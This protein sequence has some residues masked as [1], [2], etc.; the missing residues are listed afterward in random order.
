MAATLFQ[1]ILD[2]LPEDVTPLWIK[3]PL[4]VIAKIIQL[5]REYSHSLPTGPE[6]TLVQDTIVKM[7]KFERCVHRRKI[8]SIQYLNVTI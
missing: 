1:K 5:L 6:L 7:M 8:L 4:S 3:Q 2:T